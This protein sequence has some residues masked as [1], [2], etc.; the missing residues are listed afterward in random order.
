MTLTVS[1][2]GCGDDGSSFGDEGY[3]T[4]GDGGESGGGQD[5][6][7]EGGDEP[8]IP[9]EEGPTEETETETDTGEP[10][11][12][13][14][15]D[16]ILYLS[17]DDSNS[18]SSPVQVRERVLVDGLGLGPVAIRPWEFMN[19]YSF[20][21]AP[22][23]DGSLALSAE[24]R[25]LEGFPE[26]APH[27]QLQLGVTSEEMTDAERPPMNITLVLDTSGS[28]SGEPIELL[29]HS[30]RAI[31]ASLREGDKV[32]MVEWDTQNSWTLAGYAVTGPNDPQLLDKIEAL[33]AGGGTDLHGGLTSGY[34]LAQQ[35][36]DINAL[37]RLVLISDGGANAGVTDIELIAESANYGGS[38]GI[39]LV[40]AGVDLVGTY[41]DDL[42]DVVTDAGKGASVF[43][44][45][46]AEAWDTFNTNFISTMGLAARNVQ[47]ELSLPPGFE[48]VKFSGEELS[49]DPKEVEPQHL[50]PNDSMVFLQEL[51]TCAPELIDEAAQ[52]TVTAT[53]EDVSS[54]ESM[55]VSQSYSFAQ[56]L[57]SDAS[58]MAKGAAI[59]AYVD[60][61]IAIKS[62]TLTEAGVAIDAAYAA[63]AAAQAVLPGDA[64]LDEIK[65]I[66][67]AL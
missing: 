66:L 7:A 64:D 3:Y 67:D 30:C 48:I 32:S 37:N 41:N 63:I 10:L 26:D 45:N 1:L 22:A 20:D 34:E 58:R 53:W 51:V 56:L 14:V 24:L 25:M 54:F 49:S 61:L 55:E 21:Y 50:A 2:A 40:G 27:Y 52:I 16:V 4:S 44:T 62:G 42:M 12:N 28:M 19:Y 38:D 23:D 29:E 39:Y 46:E 31:A 5:G 8:V 6:G 15:D 11:C 33:T 18:M 60:A 17:P 36:W 65:Q 13:D 57:D 35:T 59:I 43:I 47:V 9:D